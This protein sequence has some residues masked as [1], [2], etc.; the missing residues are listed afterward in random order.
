MLYAKGGLVL[1]TRR[2]DHEDCNRE[3][4]KKILTAW[5]RSQAK[6]SLVGSRYT[7]SIEETGAEYNQV[8][9]KV[10]KPDFPR[11]H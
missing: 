7:N 10:G 4:N 5:Y 1:N 11:R 8:T 9:N 6:G 2:G 3:R